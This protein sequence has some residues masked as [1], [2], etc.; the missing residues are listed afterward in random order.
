MS[1]D[2][3]HVW[4]A[5]SATMTTALFR[6]S[7]V[8]TGIPSP[9]VWETMFVPS[10]PGDYRMYASWLA[11]VTQKTDNLD[12]VTHPDQHLRPAPDATY[13]L[14]YEDALQLTVARDQQK[15][16]D[17]VRQIGRAHV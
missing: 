3:D 14:Y 12:D 1:I 4:R 6:V 11:N 2:P 5:D 15:F 7:T 16:A 8:N 13:S 9:A 10:E 17:D